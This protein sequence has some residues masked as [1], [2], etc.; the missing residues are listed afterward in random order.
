MVSARFR[1]DRMAFGPPFAPRE[2]PRSSPMPPLPRRRPVALRRPG[3]WGW[4][5]VALLAALAPAAGEALA[6]G[7]AGSAACFKRFETAWKGS[8]TTAVVGCMEPEGKALFQLFAYPLSG[9]ARTMGPKQATE[10]LKAYF[11]KVTPAALAD[12]TPKKSPKSVRL[13]E[14]RYKAT[15]ENAR[16]T[17]LQV[18]L[19]QDDK[20]R[21]V[22]AS[23]TESAKPRR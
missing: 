4:V 19:K 8:D 23:V 2:H 13:Y 20:R 14:F 12:V 7:E 16:T 21:W 9:R 18:T 6:S 17:R 11:K 22:L 15:G 1:G 5:A 10:T 3:A